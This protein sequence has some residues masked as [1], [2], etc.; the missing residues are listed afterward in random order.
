M[1]LALILFDSEAKVLF[2]LIYHILER[3]N[4]S[5]LRNTGLNALHEFV[6][7][8]MFKNIDYF[9][10]NIVVKTSF[11]FLKKVLDSFI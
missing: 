7:N 1:W 5:F 9:K 8:R 4:Q 3:F 6:A 2:L 10:T 11:E